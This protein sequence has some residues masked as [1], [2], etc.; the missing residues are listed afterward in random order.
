MP[1]ESFDP[2]EVATLQPEAI[3][4]AVTDALAAVTAA[5]T[6]EQLK[7]AALAHDGDRS[8]A[9]TGQP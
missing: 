8:P 6:L 3:D 5:S 7:S 9:R 1:S 4:A 2:V